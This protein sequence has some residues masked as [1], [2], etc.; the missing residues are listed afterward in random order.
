MMIVEAQ[1]RKRIL[2]ITPDLF[3]SFGMSKLRREQRTQ[4]KPWT[5]GANFS[6]ARKEN[7]LQK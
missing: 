1:N 2:Q 6:V 3:A 4:M 5:F 7:N